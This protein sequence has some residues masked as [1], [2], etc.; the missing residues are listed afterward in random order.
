MMVRGCLVVL[1]DDGGGCL[2]VL[3]DDGG[4]AVW[5]YFGTMVGDV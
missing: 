4:G 5:V 1:M 3:M 2:V